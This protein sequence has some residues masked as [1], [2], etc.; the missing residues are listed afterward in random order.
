MLCGIRIALLDGLYNLAL[1]FLGSVADF[2]DGF[3]GLYR[4][5]KHGLFN[6]GGDFLSSVQA[7]AKLYG[8]CDRHLTGTYIMSYLSGGVSEFLKIIILMFFTFCLYILIVC[9]LRQSLCFILFSNNTI[10]LR[11][12]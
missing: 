8:P 1:L 4:A 5:G 11:F 6:A 7:T 9:A 12:C 3:W 2:N 10:P